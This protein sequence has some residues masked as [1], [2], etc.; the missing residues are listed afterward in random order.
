MLRK[1]QESCGKP[2]RVTAVLLVLMML[3]ALIA[4]GVVPVAVNAASATL[5]GSETI[6]IF[7]QDSSWQV[8]QVRVKQLGSDASVKKT[9]TLTPADNKLSVT[10]VSGTAEIVLEQFNSTKSANLT[11]M[12][13][14][15]SSASGTQ[16]VVFYDN[17]SAQWTDL[18]YYAWSKVNGV[19]IK[20]A[21]WD[22]RKS[23][24][25]L[26]TT[27]IWYA[28][29]DCNASLSSA[30]EN[31]IFTGSGSQTD[32]LTL[33]ASTAE[34]VQIYSSATNNWTQYTD[35]EKSVKA[36]VKD[37]Y[38]DSHNNLYVVSKTV[39]KWSKYNSSS[40]TATVYFK[41]NSSWDNAYVHYDD[42]VN[43]PF[44]TTVK[45]TVE[46][47][48]P[49]IFK[50][51]V[52]EG[53]M[54]SF[55]SGPDF[56]AS[57]KKDQ[58]S[59]FDDTNEPCYVSAARSWTTLDNAKA[60]DVYPSDLT[61]KDTN[62]N[63]VTPTGGGKVV[64]FDAYYYD[65]LSDNERLSDWRKYLN[66]DPFEINNQPAAGG[67]DGS[68]YRAQ[69][70]QFNDDIKNIAL[71][72]ANWRYPLFF[73]DD[74]NTNS[75]ITN[76]YNAV[77]N[78]R[79]PSITQNN[80]N[81]ANNSNYLG[82]DNSR[83]VM[84]LVKPTL[85]N[86]YL[87]ITDTKRSP[88]FDDEFLLAKGSAVNKEVLYV[89]D[90]QNYGRDGIYCNFWNDSKAFMDQHPTQ[91][92][93]NEITIGGKTG[94]LYRYLVDADMK[95]VQLSHTKDYS[96][97]F[98]S[99]DP[100]GEWVVTRFTD[101]VTTSGSYVSHNTYKSGVQNLPNT[102]NRAKIINSKF[103]FVETTDPTTKVKTYTFNSDGSSRK[104][105]IS[106]QTDKIY[107]YNNNGYKGKLDNNNGFFPF[108]G[109]NHETRNYGFGVRVDMD[110][111]IPKNGMLTAT[112]PAEF[113]YSGDDDVW[114]F[115]DGQLI[116]DIG[117][118]HTPT[119]GSINFGAGVNQIKAT[120][121]KVYGVMSTTSNSDTLKNGS[122]VEKTFTF[123]NTDPTKKHRMTVF[124]LERG[125]ND[126]NL[127]IEFSI[128]PILNELNVYK[129]VETDGINHG[130]S[131]TV[132]TLA[133]NSD[134]DFTFLQNSS[135]YGGS[136]GKTYNIV[137]ADDTT[138]TDTIN[139]GAF[140]LK[141]YEEA[142]FH[143]DTDLSFGDT[144]KITEAA[145]SYLDTGTARRQSPFVYDTDIVVKDNLY[146][147]EITPTQKNGKDVTFAF[148][149]A[150]NLSEER[151]SLVAEFT[152]TMK[153]AD[154]KIQKNLYEKGST[155]ASAH[156]TPF[157]FTLGLD[158]DND[159]TYEFYDFDYYYEGHADEVFTANE[160]V[161]QMRP[162]Q[163]VIIKGIPV[164]TPYILTEAQKAGY[165]IKD[166]S[167]TKTGTVPDAELTALIFNNEESPSAQN[168]D[169]Y[170]TLD[171][172]PYSGNEF[173]FNCAL[174]KWIKSDATVVTDATALG[175]IYAANSVSVV[176]G[177]DEL[178]VIGF[179]PFNIVPDDESSGTYI[180]EISEADKSS[181]QPWYIYDRQKYYAKITVQSGTVSAP[182][183]YKDPA[184]TQ[185]VNKV[186]FMNSTAKGSITVNKTDV[187]QTPLEGAQFAVIKVSSQ[188]DVDA[189]LTPE[190]INTLVE[191][192]KT[193]PDK[194]R[195]ETTVMSTV[196][197]NNVASAVFNDLDLYQTGG[198]FVKE[199]DAVVW[200]D[201]VVTDSDKQVYCVFEYTPA[202]GFL[203]N[204]TKTYVTFA[205]KTNASFTFGLVDAQVVMPNSSGSGSALY[206]WLGLGV[207][208]FAA[209]LFG[210]YMLMRKR[211][212][213]VHA[214]RFIQ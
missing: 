77:K 116:L 101:I 125:T 97:K 119:Q 192:N 104:D 117:G 18:K 86:G 50:A 183:F 149:N 154:L 166:S 134:F 167:Y 213:P 6:T 73:G 178:G 41:P 3:I 49:L 187:D 164:G 100:N 66:D 21:D 112:K 171:N 136:S 197:G 33:K 19:T 13:S 34:N 188:D 7:L 199:G 48:S 54:V 130:F 159:G 118:A 36:A 20:D 114:V 79:N 109:A 142:M 30:Y 5:G 43:E 214:T 158:L 144:M 182:A 56:D 202:E 16:T 14:V 124:Y 82:G 156:D 179:D 74:Y 107:Y 46:N 63:S 163:E 61:V 206:R 160:G 10:G 203:P 103:P 161:F 67:P 198:M 137:H 157:K 85:K 177:G 39:A 140:K 153:V 58:G 174:V 110:F 28:V 169:V 98:W 44:Y 71:G 122:S 170:K 115:I 132:K 22:H 126:S 200:S 99:Y 45:M 120:T 87:M 27:D 204:Y 172:V 80:F 176:R 194:V 212:K 150:R 146:G 92:T 31:I 111:T 181:T 184:C 155:T 60:N 106:I 195:L 185:A 196:S 147:D 89:L 24:T 64:G 8:S 93:D 133:E 52:Y 9:E 59:V 83:S 143:N 70:S 72:N 209:L 32:D 84:G 47:D 2:V 190:N 191:A 193:D 148:K 81:A 69:F 173:T 40:P 208:V 38:S 76:Y 123:N 35:V 102:A 201:S 68:Y 139:N 129:E 55:S 211:K 186:T 65:Y 11:S 162:S 4:V 108:N 168:I 135:G 151:T 37:R 25:R 180:L 96:Q 128:Q 127:S 141:N 26:G 152:N 205:D 75:F 51:P 165:R 1:K 12:R 94:I 145:A 175:R 42:D 29:I 138:T 207:I 62:F 91:V 189:L 105:N 210:A 113:K 131:D 15:I 78:S 121:N 57:D 53:A 90:D 95:G 88:Y 17:T 23:L